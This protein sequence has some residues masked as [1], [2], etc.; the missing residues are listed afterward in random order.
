MIVLPPAV[1]QVTGMPDLTL[2]YLVLLAGALVL[3]AAAF[4]LW[5]FEL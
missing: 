4:V 3:A 5:K 1:Q 2:N